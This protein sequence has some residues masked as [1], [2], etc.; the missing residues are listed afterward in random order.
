[1]AILEFK[2][3]VR[4]AG[5][6][7]VFLTVLINDVANH[8]QFKH[9]STNI[10]RHGNVL[11]LP[12][13]H[14]TELLVWVLR[15]PKYTAPRYCRQIGLPQSGCFCQ[16]SHYDLHMIARYCIS[17]IISMVTL[18]LGQVTMGTLDQYLLNCMGLPISR[19]S[20]PHPKKL[21][22][23]ENCLPLHSHWPKI[24]DIIYVGNLWLHY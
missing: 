16:P 23:P 15:N 7:F 19:F 10:F 6:E 5:Y 1:M 8:R 21:K 17:G 2:N 9:K 22:M 20:L 3:C 11:F 24:H 14:S 4:L 18:C 12:C 13:F